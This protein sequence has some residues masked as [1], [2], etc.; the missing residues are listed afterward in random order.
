MTTETPLHQRLIVGVGGAVAIAALFLPWASV[1][2]ADQTGWQFN[3]VAAVYFA[4]AGVF[5]IATAITGGRYG[6]CRPDVSLIGATDLLNTVGM[7]LFAWLILD[8][9]DSATRQ[10]G[11]YV[12]LI[13]TAVTAFAVAD[14]RPLHGAPWFPPTDTGRPASQASVAV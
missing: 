14:Y 7:L 11:V 3:T 12:A 13:A 9:P 10:P 5:G 1:A 2:G 6:L 8:F 4:I